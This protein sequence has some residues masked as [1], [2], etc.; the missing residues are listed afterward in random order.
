[1][2]AATLTAML[3]SVTAQAQHSQKERCAHNVASGEMMCV[4]RL[5]HCVDVTIDGQ[6]TTALADEATAQ[7]VHAVKHDQD[8]CWQIAQPVSTKLRVQAK[9]GGIFPSFLGRIEKISANVYDIGDFD[10][11]LDSRLDDIEGTSMVA[12]G[13]PNGTWQLTAER[14]LKGGEYVIVFRV[15][16]EG[17]WDKQAVLL[18]LDPKLQPVAA[19]KTGGGK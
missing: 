19:D 2:I 16:G 3:L 14:P 10:P 1:M 17:N 7:R 5:G 15:F 6:K 11:K 13:D 8:V 12:D 18:K 4:N 9:A